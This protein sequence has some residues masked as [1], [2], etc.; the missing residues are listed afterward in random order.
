MMVV[1]ATFLL[2]QEYSHAIKKIKSLAHLNH[3][4][5]YILTGHLS[6]SLIK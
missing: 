2:S 5:S 1:T 4:H 3:C 6:D